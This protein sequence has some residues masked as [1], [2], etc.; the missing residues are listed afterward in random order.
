MSLV[1]FRCDPILKEEAFA[2]LKTLNTTPSDLFKDVLSYVVQNR[3]LPIESVLM[4]ATDLA[5]K[6]PNSLSLKEAFLKTWFSSKLPK[7]T[8]YIQNSKQDPDID[9]FAL[10]IHAIQQ[11]DTS[12]IIAHH[13]ISQ[14]IVKIDHLIELA[15]NNDREMLILDISNLDRGIYD[16]NVSYN[17]I[18]DKSILEA[19]LIVLAPF[20]D[21]SEAMEYAQVLAPTYIKHFGDRPVNLDFEKI[22]TFNTSIANIAFYSILK[23]ETEINAFKAFHNAV[24]QLMQ[25]HLSFVLKHTD[26]DEKLNLRHIIQNRKIVLIEDCNNDAIK[27]FSEELKWFQ[28]LFDADMQCTVSQLLDYEYPKHLTHVIASPPYLSPS[29]IKGAFACFA[30]KLNINIH[31]TMTYKDVTSINPTDNAV[32]LANSHN[33]LLSSPEANEDLS[34]FKAHLPGNSFSALSKLKENEVLL[35]GANQLQILS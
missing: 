28:S 4:S 12:V 31:F 30:R 5:K 9:G 20:H 10:A 17:P 7:N 23:T 32:L 26:E 18:E 15:N 1:N 11:P 13:S 35:I 21:R 22:Q 27:P 25:S 16:C 14:S 6:D 24:D 8:L 34:F 2:I 3:R 29:S 19:L 33:I